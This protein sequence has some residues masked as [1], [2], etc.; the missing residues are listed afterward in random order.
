MSGTDLIRPDED[1]LILVHPLTQ[2][3]IDLVGAPNDLLA[4]FLSDLRNSELALKE[5]KRIVSDEV[6]RRQDHAGEWTTRA[7][8]GWVLKGQSPEPVKEYDELALRS[9][10]LELVDRGV[11][12]IEAVDRAVQTNITY[13]ARE[14]GLNR[15]RKLGGEVAEIVER[16]T[17]R[18]ER[19]R[20]VS[21]QNLKES[22]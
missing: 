5:A 13:K 2:E 6:L 18:S 15:L 10:L 4:R 1:Q 16:H 19:R 20:Y 14:D 12:N 17:H 11:L 7:E 21:V 3:A 9:E 8:G 22:R